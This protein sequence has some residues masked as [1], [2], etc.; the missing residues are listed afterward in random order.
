MHF[1]RTRAYVPAIG[2]RQV[3]LAP[4]PASVIFSTSQGFRLH[5]GP[6]GELHALSPP[7]LLCAL[8]I[9]HPGLRV[10]DGHRKVI[11]YLTENFGQELWNRTRFVLTM[12]NRVEHEKREAIP[13]IRETI[14][15][16]LKQVLRDIGVEEDIVKRQIV[17]LAGRGQEKLMVND[18]E[19]IMWNEICF[20]ECLNAIGDVG[21]EITLMQAR[22][23]ELVWKEVLPDFEFEDTE[24]GASDGYAWAAYIT[25][26]IGFTLK[27]AH[28]G[29]VSGIKGMAIGGAAGAV[30]G[31]IS[32]G[33][34]GP[35][36][37]SYMK[38]KSKTQ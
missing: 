2:E 29:S 24:G 4:A 21:G 11:T 8:D 38:K 9:Y 6:H 5:Y 12:I 16:N 37:T 23:G 15:K 26:I 36:I 25:T 20:Q 27:G 30:V 3:P 34:M 32:A 28:M 18:R 17:S 7:A 22:Y 33:A 1:S 13:R 19:E 35:L 31:L 10:K 14:E